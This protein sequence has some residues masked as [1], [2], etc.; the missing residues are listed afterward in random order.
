M[1]LWACSCLRCQQSKIQT[2]ACSSDPSIP[3]PTRRFSHVHIDIVGPLPSSQGYSY[4][5]TMMDRTTSWPELATLSSIS[6]ESCVCAFLATWVSRFGVPAI[7]TS[8]RGA[9]LTS[10]IWASL[11]IS[12][13]TTTSFHPQSNG[14]IERFHRSLKA[15]LRSRLASSA[16]FQHL[17]LVLLG[18]RSQGRHQLLCL[19]G[20]VWRSSHCSW[21]VPRQS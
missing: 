19:Q 3:V 21:R 11:G 8:D 16:W 18:L 9:Q 4:L 10:S 13:S 20:C 12:V 7:I 1:G 5:L 14:L 2:H 6:A 15:A 17:P